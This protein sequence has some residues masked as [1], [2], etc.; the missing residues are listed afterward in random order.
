MLILD[1]FNFWRICWKFRVSDLFLR[2]NFMLW[3]D[4]FTNIL[5][6]VIEFYI[7]RIAI[8]LNW[9]KY[10]TI[11]DVLRTVLSIRCHVW[12]CLIIWYF[13]NWAVCYYWVYFS[14][15]N[16]VFSWRETDILNWII[17]IRWRNV[18]LDSFRLEF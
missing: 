9:Y 3:F 13:F 12:E 1:Y 16:W 11:V 4:Y 8:L 15:Y 18:H 14:F 17:R 7:G 6:S 2:L 10:W 5:I